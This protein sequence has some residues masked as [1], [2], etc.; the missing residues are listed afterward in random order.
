MKSL[1]LAL[2]P[3]YLLANRLDGFHHFRH[4]RPIFL[5]GDVKHALWF[6]LPRDLLAHGVPPTLLERH[7][8]LLPALALL[9]F[10]TTPLPFL[11][12]QLHLQAIPPL[13]RLVPVVELVILGEDCGRPWRQPQH[14]AIQLEEHHLRA[15]DD[16]CHE[17][18]RPL[19]RD[20]IA[21]TSGLV[22]WTACLTD[23]RFGQRRGLLDCA[24]PARGCVL[25]ALLDADYG[26]MCV[27]IFAPGVVACTVISRVQPNGG[28]CRLVPCIS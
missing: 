12:I 10:L 17:K 7:L 25:A 1:T 22:S 15:D 5:L 19:R 3:P 11:A 6:L 18:R 23:E 2:V 20:G 4:A 8:L 26:V 16:Q 28:V 14:G 13:L 27:E 24:R 21:S 9:P